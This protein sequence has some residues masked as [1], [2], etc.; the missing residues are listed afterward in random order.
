MKIPNLANSSKTKMNLCIITLLLILTVSILAVT[1]V[2]ADDK[3]NY[4]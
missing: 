3:K 4:S 1:P 2:L